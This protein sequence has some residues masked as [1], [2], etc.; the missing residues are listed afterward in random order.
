MTEEHPIHDLMSTALENIKDMV[1]VD[2]IIGE[3]IETPDRSTVILPVSKVGFGFAS[4]GSQFNGGSSEDSDQESSQLP[5]GGGAGGGVSITPIAFLIVRP[6][7][8]QMVHLNEN[9]HFLDKL[10]EIAPDVV[11]D[12]K[13]MIQDRFKRSN[14]RRRSSSKEKDEDSFDDSDLN[15]PE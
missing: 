8:I 6:K 4:G 15:T 7:D 5:F 1:D 13:G 9:T 3:P 14:K 2:T 11:N 10:M 12:A